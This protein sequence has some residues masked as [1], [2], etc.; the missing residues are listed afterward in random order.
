MKTNCCIA[1]LMLLAGSVSGCAN[2]QKSMA[3]GK[4]RRAAYAEAVR[5]A[6]AA[7]Y[8]MEPAAVYA[9][10]YAVVRDGYTIERE[11]ERRGF[12]ESGWA[13]SGPDF[14]GVKRRTKVSAE[15]VG[16]K[17]IRVVVNA[18]AE[19]MA[20]G[21]TTWTSAS[22]PS[23]DDLVLKIDERIRQRLPS[24]PEGAAAAASPTPSSK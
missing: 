11:S 22:P 9:E 5:K 7:C 19:A 18:S 15:L 1:L 6:R 3:E 17:C 23:T 20:K 8:E 24:K 21:T 4:A 16:D 2:I 12:I 14:A 13:E 10:V